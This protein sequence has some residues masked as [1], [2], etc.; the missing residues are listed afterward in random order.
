MIGTISRFSSSAKGYHTD[1]T[2]LFMEHSGVRVRHFKGRV[3]N[4][5]REKSSN[6]QAASHPA[7][8]DQH[9]GDEQVQQIKRK[10]WL[11]SPIPI[12]YALVFGA[13]LSQLFKKGHLSSSRMTRNKDSGDNFQSKR[14]DNGLFILGWM[15]H[16][17]SHPVQPSDRYGFA[18][19]GLR[20]RV[21]ARLLES[22]SLAITD[23]FEA[24][25]WPFAPGAKQMRLAHFGSEPPISAWK[26]SAREESQV[27]QFQ[28]SMRISAAEQ[29]AARFESRSN[30]DEGQEKMMVAQEPQIIDER[31]IVMSLGRSE[32][33]FAMHFLEMLRNVHK[34]NLPVE[35]YYY[36]DDDL[37]AYMREFL[38]S[39]YKGV[40]TIDLEELKSFDPTLAKLSRQGW[41]L[42]PFALLASNFSEVMLADADVVFLT[43]PEEFFEVEGY[44][45][46]GTLFFHD[47]D[48]FREGAS[49]I[50][51]Q[52]LDEQLGNRGPSSILSQS[53]FWKG[54]GI[55][56][57]ESGIVVADK[58]SRAVFSALFFAA[59]Q[60]TGS[61]RERTTYRVFWGMCG[62]R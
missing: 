17:L 34:S 37:P 27:K 62:C 22:Q 39:S 3:G 59:W 61:I 32:V 18:E 57:Q 7:L 31:G 60:N 4:A 35:L 5:F 55:Y 42:K 13:V 24:K 53:S 11:N 26:T 33:R 23:D 10:S 41:A 15:E 45:K 14:S 2:S 1:I 51:H 44:K 49:N 28:S 56:E 50:I 12:L 36:G 8:V 25:L 6:E 29:Q 40:R 58:R 43:R 54:K 19:M 48:H 20:T 9:D 16:I 21:Y 30:D 47:R 38:E 52:F 46:T